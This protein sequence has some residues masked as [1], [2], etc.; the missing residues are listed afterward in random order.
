MKKRRKKKKTKTKTTKKKKKKKKNESKKK[1][2]KIKT[3]DKTNC[4]SITLLQTAC[5]FGF[6]LNAGESHC[7]HFRSRFP[8]SE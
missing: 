4:R 3:D 6:V 8:V 2:T 1:Q 7:L 5:M